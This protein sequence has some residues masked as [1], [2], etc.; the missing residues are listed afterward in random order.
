[1]KRRIVERDEDAVRKELCCKPSES[2]TSSGAYSISAEKAQAK[3]GL[4]SK[5]P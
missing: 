2:Y 3:R 4:R 1:M 5:R